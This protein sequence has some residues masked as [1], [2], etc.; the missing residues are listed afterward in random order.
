MLKDGQEVER[1]TVRVN[2]PLRYNG[3]A[4][5]QAFFGSAAVMTIKDAHGNVL[6]SEGVPLA[7]RHAEG[8]PLGHLHHPRH[9]A[10]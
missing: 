9:H 2:D 4:F 5:Y 8:R 7:W 10:T 3:F 1:H 6:A